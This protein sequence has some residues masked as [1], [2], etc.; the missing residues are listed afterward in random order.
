MDTVGIVLAAGGSTRMGFPKALLDVE[1]RPLVVQHIE[2]LRTVCNRILVV[3]GAHADL[4]EGALPADAEVVRN[5]HWDTTG[6]WDSLR[7]A[8]DRVADEDVAFVTNVDTLPCRP[9]T[10]DALLA[11]GAPCV[12]TCQGTR[13]HPVLVRVGELRTSA[14]PLDHAT[15]Q[16]RLVPV[17]DP[18]VLLNLN[19]P[20]DLEGLDVHGGVRR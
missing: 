13:G 11:T 17:S 12:P 10:L 5:P 15:S 7:L 6:P 3:I 8:L 9:A 19:R 2:R 4:I 14:G 20:T 16:A 1:G 18:H